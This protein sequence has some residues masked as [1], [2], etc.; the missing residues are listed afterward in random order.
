[1]NMLFTVCGRAGSKGLKNKNIRPFLGIPLVYYTLSAI[2]LYRQKH[3]SRYTI[4]TYLNTDS[5]ELI[6][7]TL[8]AVPDVNIIRRSAALSG[9]AVAKI[10]VVKDC[11][12]EAE[13]HYEVLFDVVVDLD[14]TSPLR[15]LCDIENAVSKKQARQDVDIVFSVTPAR[16]NPYFNMVKRNSDRTVSK[17]LESDYTSRQQA[18]EMFDM[19]ASIYAYKAEFLRSNT[20]KLLFDGLCDSIEMPDTGFLDI[21]SGDD[22]VM[23]EVIAEHLFK[24]DPE[25]GVIAQEAGRKV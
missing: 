2:Q 7:Q 19:N 25:Y 5:E 4:H 14:I 17:V 3:E 12:I 22:F 11:L 1:M 10:A 24:N 9:D 6:I 21:D 20:S 15:R 23:L 8:N 16:R 18:P 13:R